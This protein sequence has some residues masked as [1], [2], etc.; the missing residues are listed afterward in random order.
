MSYLQGIGDRV[1]TA[2]SRM[3][4]TPVVMRVRKV[5]DVD[6]IEYAEHVM[7]ERIQRAMHNISIDDSGQSSSSF[8]TIEFHICSPRLIYMPQYKI[9]IYVSTVYYMLRLTCSCLTPIQSTTKAP[10][11]HAIAAT[12]IQIRRLLTQSQL[13][14]AFFTSRSS[15][16]LPFPSQALWTYGMMIRPN[17][18]R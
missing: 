10:T 13:F 9:D 1:L 4:S 17:G 11:A 7:K 3:S 12:S 14:N 6:E 2:V 18:A 5:N 15:L 16:S 8:P